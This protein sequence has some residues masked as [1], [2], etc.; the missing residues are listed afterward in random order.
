MGDILIFFSFP[1]YI[2]KEIFYKY[3]I[4]AFFALLEIQFVKLYE[5]KKRLTNLLIIVAKKDIRQTV[6]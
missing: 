5:V 6:L 4:C 3:Q 1:S 2:S